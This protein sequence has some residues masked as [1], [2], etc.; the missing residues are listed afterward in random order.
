M[1]VASKDDNTSAT[2]TR[3]SLRRCVQGGSGGKLNFLVANGVSR[4]GYLPNSH[5]ET[6]KPKPKATPMS[7]FPIQ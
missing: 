4:A 2:S 7:H 5:L 1:L 3:G 6:P